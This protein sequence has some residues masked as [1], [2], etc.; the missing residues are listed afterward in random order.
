MVIHGYYNKCYK[1]L[2][3]KYIAYVMPGI[4]SPSGAKE[5]I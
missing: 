4:Y 1:F 5:V 3:D 2:K